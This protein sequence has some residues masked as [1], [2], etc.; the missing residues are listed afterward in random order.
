MREA[1]G[2]AGYSGNA[3]ASDPPQARIFPVSYI[4]ALPLAE[5]PPGRVPAINA[6]PSPFVSNQCMEVLGPAWN[7]AE[8]DTQI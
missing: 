6:E 4:T 8:Q 5:F 3:N 1:S 2:D 7:T